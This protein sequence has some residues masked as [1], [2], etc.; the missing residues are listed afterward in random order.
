MRHLVSAFEEAQLE[1]PRLVLQLDLVAVL[2]H[3]TDGPTRTVQAQ[4]LAPVRAA[5]ALEAVQE[6]GLFFGRPEAAGCG[7]G[8]FMF[9]GGGF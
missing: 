7:D 5:D 4:D 8:G 6:R 2:E 1:V 3:L 9:L